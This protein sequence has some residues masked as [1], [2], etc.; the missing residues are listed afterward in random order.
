MDLKTG[1]MVWWISQLT[2]NDAFVVGCR[3]G[4]GK[5]SRRTSGPISTSATRRSCATLPG[6]KRVLVDRT[7]VGRRCGASIPTAEGKV[8]W[9]YRAGK[10]SALGG[11]E[12]GSAADDTN[13]YIPVSDVLAAPGE[14]G[15]IHA[16]KLRHRRTA[17]GSTP[18]PKLECT[19]GRGCTGRSR[20]PRR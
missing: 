18:A 6:G 2:P 9:Q 14:A 13:A 19:S 5:L 17:S 4:R 11:I 16:V 10:G 7:E 12:W 3:P 8:L 1:K 15:G 20:R